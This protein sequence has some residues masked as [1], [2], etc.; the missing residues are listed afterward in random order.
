M[1][2]KEHAIKKF[3][4]LINHYKKKFTSNLETASENKQSMDNLDKIVVRSCDALYNRL[5][6]LIQLAHNGAPTPDS[7][8][9]FEYGFYSSGLDY[10]W[11]TKDAHD[12][13][14]YMCLDLRAAPY[15][16]NVDII[17]KADLEAACKRL[18]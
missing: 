13:I 12:F 18:H 8:Q 11:K 5:N 7:S 9:A 14:Y 6:A 1:E 16:T 4:G 10:V 3:R 17:D 15:T 2:E